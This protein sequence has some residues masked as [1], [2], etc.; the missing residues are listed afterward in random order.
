MSYEKFGGK[1]PWCLESIFCAGGCAELR[2]DVCIILSFGKVRVGV[3][4]K[5]CII[6]SL[7]EHSITPFSAATPTNM[8]LAKDT[9]RG[10]S[11]FL[12]R[13]TPFLF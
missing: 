5:V 8:P 6:L 9:H 13:R 1:G 12:I 10:T 3:G 7:G 11:G 2:V 4:V